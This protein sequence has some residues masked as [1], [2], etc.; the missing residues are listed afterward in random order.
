[1]VSHAVRA[2]SRS[3]RCQQASRHFD[4]TDRSRWQF[5]EHQRRA[6]CNGIHRI[7][8][9]KRSQF[10]SFRTALLRHRRS[11]AILLRE[12]GSAPNAERGGDAGGDAERPRAVRSDPPCHPHQDA[13]QPRARAHG[14]AGVYHG[15][16]GTDGEKRVAYYSAAEQQRKDPISSMSFV[17]N[18]TGRGY[19][20]QRAGSAS[21]PRSTPSLQ[22]SA[23]AG[24]RA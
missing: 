3:S 20:W 1:M 14:A 12:T 9:S 10:H 11:R 23:R 8:S 19:H 16:A 18:S 15:P 6:K 21:S 13:A 24:L 4:R 7:R 5:R 2:R 17:R 22:R